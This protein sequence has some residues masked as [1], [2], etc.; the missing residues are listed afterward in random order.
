M[1]EKKGGGTCKSSCNTIEQ[2]KREERGIKKEGK[3]KRW[4]M[5]PEPQNGLF[6]L[7]NRTFQD[8][9]SGGSKI[10]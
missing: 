6:L 3:G 1:D 4:R 5:A 10:D 7:K 8:G 9:D 2:Q